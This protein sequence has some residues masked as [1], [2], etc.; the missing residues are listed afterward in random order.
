MKFNDR[1][2]LDGAGRVSKKQADAH[3][4]GEYKRLLLSVGY[5]PKAEGARSNVRAL[6]MLPMLCRNRSGSR[7]RMTVDQAVSVIRK[8]RITPRKPAP[9]RSAISNLE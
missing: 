9:R 5:S 8:F 2:V 3:A 1:N 6:E 7:L 4:E